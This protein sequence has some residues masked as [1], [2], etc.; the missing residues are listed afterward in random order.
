MQLNE[1]TVLGSLVVFITGIFTWIFKRQI[2]R[3]DKL[4]T[5]NTDAQVS[6]AAT[7]EIVKSMH[8][9]LKSHMEKEEKD[10]VFT[11]DTMTA[12]HE[13]LAVLA[14][15]SEHNSRSGDSS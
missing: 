11:I 14:D 7:A 1:T 5:A 9:G 4:E 10:R 6:R 3:I 13:K 2:N 8:M 12:I 15:R